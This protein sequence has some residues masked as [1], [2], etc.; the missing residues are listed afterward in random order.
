MKPT[1][2]KM[3]TLFISAMLLTTTAACSSSATN[4]EAPSA[5]TQDKETTQEKQTTQDKAAT[6]KSKVK[7]DEAKATELIAQFEGKTP[8]KLVVPSVALVEIL[9]VLGVKPV[10]VPTS[11]IELPEGVNDVTKI[12]SALKPDIEQITN[13]QPDLILGPSSIKD[14]LEKQFKPASLKTAYLPTDSLEELKLTTVVLSRVF[15]QE[16]KAEEFLAKLHAQEKEALQVAKG[17]NAPKILFLFGSAESFMLMNENTFA[18]SLAKKMGASNVVSDVLKSKEA[19]I[20]L[21][22]EN[23]VMANPDVILLVAH[24]DADAAIKKFEEDVKKNGAWEKLNAFKNGKVKALNYNQFGVASIVKA[25]EA[26]KELAEK[27]Y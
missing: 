7:V 14:S 5:T 9:D 4:G 24:G 16:K 19:Y 8:A 25:P 12:G 26:Y 10:G 27:L 18:G 22:I 1:T 11:T 13:L 23:V 3:G 6:Q 17:K 2:Y 21:N 15:K 20:P